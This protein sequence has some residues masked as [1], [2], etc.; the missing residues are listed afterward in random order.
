MGTVFMK[1]NIL[2]FLLISLT[3]TSCQSAVVNQNNQTVSSENTRNTKALATKNISEKD[4]ESKEQE[5]KK[6]SFFGNYQM[7]DDFAKIIDQNSID[8]AYSEEMETFQNSA[9]FNTQGWV[10]LEAKYLKIW[11]NELNSIYKKLLTKLNEKEKNILIESQ[12]GWVQFHTNELAFVDEVFYFRKSG[13][14]F[15]S[16]G[17]VQTVA[18]QS[19]RIRQR[20]LELMEYYY[21]LENEI[22]F[23]YKGVPTKK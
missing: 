6:Y 15:G 13:Q 23:E 1:K 22:E 17:R 20:T 11:D 19:S 5:K 12:K 14:L 10:E 21:L 18:T 2:L 3:L 8:R 16:Q 7:K 4:V 9:E